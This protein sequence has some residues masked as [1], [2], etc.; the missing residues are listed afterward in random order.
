[1]LGLLSNG[2]STENKFLHNKLIVQI[3]NS[4]V[5]AGETPFREKILSAR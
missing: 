1:V 2:A 5:W 3:P 4:K